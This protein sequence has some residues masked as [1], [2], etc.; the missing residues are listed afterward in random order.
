MI[1]EKALH[2]NFLYFFKTPEEVANQAIDSDCH[3]VGISTLGAG[4][5]T[6][7]PQLIQKLKDLNR[8]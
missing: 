2:K 8:P 4:H 5:K 6:L 7:I 1:L 3:V